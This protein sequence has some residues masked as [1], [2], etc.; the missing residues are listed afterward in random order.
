MGAHAILF[1]HEETEAQSFSYT[2]GVGGGG[3]LGVHALNLGAI[4]S[5]S[6]RGHPIIDLLGGLDHPGQAGLFPV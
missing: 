3:L 6:P 5:G 1:T 2:T 4:A